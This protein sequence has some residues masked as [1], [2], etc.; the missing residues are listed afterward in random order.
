V[1]GKL[2]ETIK[3]REDPGLFFRSPTGTSLKLPLAGTQSRSGL[4]IVT[5]R[6]HTGK[7]TQR[8]IDM[9]REQ[10][11][12]TTIV[13]S[14]SATKFCILAEGTS[15]VYPGIGPTVEWDTAAGETVLESSGGRV[16]S[17]NATRCMV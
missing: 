12:E 8:F 6:S 7:D 16:F 14:G 17:L 3:T 13:P 15:D 2:S 9:L 5:S 11:S 10:F 4:V 1:H